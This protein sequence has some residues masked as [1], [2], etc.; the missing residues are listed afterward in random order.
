MTFDSMA[1]QYYVGLQDR[2]L[3]P[4]PSDTDSYVYTISYHN[5]AAPDPKNTLTFSAS[6]EN[7]PS[8]SHALLELR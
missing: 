8:P 7:S 3:R 6:H 4:A 5:N 1:N 2:E